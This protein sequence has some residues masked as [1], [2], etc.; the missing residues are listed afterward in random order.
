MPWTTLLLPRADPSERQLHTGRRDG[1]QYPTGSIR[2]A[3]RC[4]LVYAALGFSSRTSDEIKEGVTVARVPRLDAH[5][6]R[7]TS[8]LVRVILVQT[9]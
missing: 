2:R 1:E 3:R 7:W 5:D 6:A 4:D 9:C 8:R